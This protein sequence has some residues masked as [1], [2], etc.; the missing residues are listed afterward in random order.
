MAAPPQTPPMRPLPPTTPQPPEGHFSTAQRLGRPA[1]LGSLWLPSLLAGISVLGSQANYLLFHTLGELFSIVLALVALVV[2]T[3]SLQFTRNHFVVFIAV[4]LGWCGGL[5]LVHTLA[6]KGM[7]LLPVDNANP[8]TQLWM[9]AR[10]LQ[11][12]ALL[13][14][15]WFLNR[16]VRLRWLHLGFGSAALLTVLAIAGERFPDAYVEGQGLTPFKVLGEYLIIAVLLLALA[17]FWQQRHWMSSRLW[18]SLSAALVFMVLSEFAFTRY[19]SVYGAANMVGHVLKIYAAWY[20]YLAL[21]QTTLRE[22][23][24]MLARAAST[25]DAVP[26]PTLVTDLQGQILQANRAAAEFAGLP[27]E[28]LVGQSCHA[29]FHDD[30]LSQADCPVCAA[31]QPHAFHERIELLRMGGAQAVEC[32]IAPYTGHFEVPTLVQVV[33]D[34]TARR[35]AQTQAKESEERFRRMIEQTISGIYVRRG[36]RFIY[37][38]PRFCEITGWSAQELLDRPALDLTEGDPQ[39]R[40]RIQAIWARLERGE[41][42][43]SYSVPLRRKDGQLIELG[44]NAT[45]LIWDDGLPATIAMAQ[46][47]TERKKAEDQIAHYVAQLER[48]MRG[49]LQA[50]SSMVELRDPYTAGHERRVGLIASAIAKEMGWDA[51]RCETLEMAG[52]VHDIGKIAVPLELLTKP[53]QLHPL[54][55]ALIQR[56]AQ[57]GYDILKDVPFPIPLADIA[58][59]HHER[60]DGS[61]YPQGL[62]GE[63]ILPEARVLAVADV[64]ESMAA[65]RP[66]RPALGLAPALAEVEAG[67]GRLYDAAVVDAALRLFREQGWPLPQ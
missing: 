37:V 31:P 46:D 13:G 36:E 44:L 8:A 32:S 45:Q 26:D 62:R 24:S 12:L 42:N 63:A 35:H 51:S 41:R 55:M 66:Y 47:I 17:R 34:V 39:T 11:A 5:D 50:I 25:Y 30:R 48:S 16:T 9:A 2:A 56:H 6:Y 20:V 58:H 59:Q 65:H 52:L 23:F 10:S 21:V 64:I 4:A 28:R 57:A 15:T 14:A 18:A 1:V 60:M 43:I 67:R 33:R 29:L 49:T 54:E 53:T 38:N 3:T 22:P 7:G 40:T 27:I 19:V 61:G